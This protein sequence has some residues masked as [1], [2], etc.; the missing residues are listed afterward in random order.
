MAPRPEHHRTLACASAHRRSNAADPRYLRSVPDLARSFLRGLEGAY[1]LDGPTLHAVGPALEVHLAA[2]RAKWPKVALAGEDFAEHLARCAPDVEDL[3][4]ALDGLC[5]ADVYLACACARGDRA[6]LEAFEEHVMPQ[7]PRAIVRIDRDDAFVREVMEEVRI[8][9]LVGDGREPRVASYLGR[10]PLTSWVQ[11]TAIRTAYSL[12]RRRS[13]EEPVEEAELELSL[14][15]SPELAHLRATV[16]TPFR[17]AFREALASL[18]PRERTVLRLYLIEEV[19]A[20]TLA[21]MYGVH[22][23]TI[24]R[25]IGAA[26][27]QVHDE[28]RRRLSSALGLDANGFESLMRNVLSG[29]DVSLA[30]FLERP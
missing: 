6:A 24:A 27:Q 20:E 15:D 4:H 23:A 11:V 13:P 26:R 9:L 3:S 12:K 28:T 7:V 8:K 2:A 19:S 30:S 29:L 14:D 16:Q 25:W 17:V 18:A 21:T 1:E 5:T 10:G 22:R